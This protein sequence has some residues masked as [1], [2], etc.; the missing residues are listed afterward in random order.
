MTLVVFHWENGFPFRLCRYEVYAKNEALDM[1][2][3]N[4]KVKDAFELKAF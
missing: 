3:E 1:N 2:K 4:T